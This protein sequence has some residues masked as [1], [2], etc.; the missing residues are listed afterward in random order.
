M[1]G[2][3]IFIVLDYSGTQAHYIYPSAVLDYSGMQAHYIYPSA[4]LDYSGMQAL[5]SISKLLT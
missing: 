4:V 2:I 1:G 5:H 3:N